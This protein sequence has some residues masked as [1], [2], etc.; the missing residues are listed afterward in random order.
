MYLLVAEEGAESTVEW[1][2][3]FLWHAAAIL[4]FTRRPR[5]AS[6]DMLRLLL[7]LAVEEDA[8]S[9]VWCTATSLWQRAPMC[10]RRPWHIGT[11][12]SGPAILIALEH[13]RLPRDLASQTAHWRQTPRL[14]PGEWWTHASCT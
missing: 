12:P 4:I 5:Q 1:T 13:R 9:M 14:K 11:T 7:P 6:R 8:E 3:T 2:A 10:Q